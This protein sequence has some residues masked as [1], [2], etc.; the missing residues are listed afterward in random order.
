MNESPNVLAPPPLIFLGALILGLALERLWRIEGI[1]HR[2]AGYTL[3]LAGIVLLMLAIQTFRRAGTNVQTRKPSTAIV[4]RGP[5]RYSRNPIY[6][7]MAAMLVGIGLAVG[8][9]WTILMV[10]PFFAII[11]FGVVA[12]EERYLAAKF[13]AAYETYRSR[14]RRWI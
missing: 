5:Y 12:R 2:G 6:L 9:A 14:V 11:R 10:I 13:G 8:S 1:A 7:G 3:F 4:E